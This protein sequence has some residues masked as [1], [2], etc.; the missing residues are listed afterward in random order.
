MEVPIKSIYLSSSIYP[1]GWKCLS[2]S[3]YPSRWKYM[4]DPFPFRFH[5]PFGMEVPI[6]SIYPLSWKVPVESIYPSGW[7][8]TVG[9]I[10]PSVWKCPSS[11]PF[12]FHLLF[13]MEVPDKSIYPLGWKYSSGLFTLQVENTIRV[14]FTLQNGSTHR[15]HLPFGFHL[16][17]RMEVPIKSIYHSGSIYPSGW[18]CPS[19]Y[20]ISTMDYIKSHTICM[21]P[22]HA[23]LYGKNSHIT[24]KDP[25]T[26]LYPPSMGSRALRS[27]NINS[28]SFIQRKIICSWDLSQPYTTI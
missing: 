17:F 19:G 1:S 22:T 26:Y 9:S 18:K 16:P 20:P 5:L 14:P 8:V 24:P 25:S 21:F 23:S 27:Q 2:G 11:S 7:K 6:E 10:Y 13:R 4:S 3:I 15:I 12:K 28:V